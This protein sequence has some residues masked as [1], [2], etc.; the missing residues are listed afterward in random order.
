[1]R[2][3]I[4]K[5]LAHWH[6]SHP[7]RMFA[8]VILI[9]IFLAGLAGQMRI[10]MRWSDLLPSGDKRSEQFNKII[11]EF[12]TSTSLV[13]V[14]Q[15][16]EGRIKEFADQLAPRILEVT[17]TSKNESNQKKIDKINK[18]IEKLKAKPNKEPKIESRE[19]EIKELQARINKKLF[20]RV[21]YKA[22]ID[23]LKEHMLML[24]KEDDLKNLKDMFMDPN[25]TGLITNINNSLEKEYV[26][27]EE[28]I[29]TR[30]K[31]DGAFGFLDGIQNL[32][33]TLQKA[34]K[35]DNISEE[36]VLA[37]ADKLLF[38]EPYLLSYN[39]KALLLNAIPNFSLID[40]GLIIIAA[41]SVQA[42]INEMSKD[43]PDVEAGLTGFIATERDENVYASRSLGYS[44][45]IAVI[46]I[47]ILLMISFRMWVAPLFAVI[48]LIVG[49]IWAVGIT[50]I[51]VGHLN[52]MT[53]MMSIILL[54]LGIDFSIHLISGFAEWRSAGDSIGKA[55]KK[56]FLKSGKGIVTGAVTTAFAFMALIIS[57]S[58]GMKEMGLVIGT[59]LLAV[60]LTTMLFLPV[61]LVFRERRIERMR[62][63]KV[64]KF[65]RRDISFRFL[66]RASEWLSKRYV[67]TII[68]SIVISGLL[69]W[70]AFK[71]K[72]DHNY[73]NLEPKGLTSITLIDTVLEKF[74]LS[75]DYA[76]VIADNVDESREL[77]KRYRDLGSAARTDDI[78]LFLPSPEQQQKRIPHILEIRDKAQ[79]S[80]VRDRILQNEYT[81]LS[82]EI[83]RL[84]M[85]IMEMQDMAFIGGQDKVDDKCKEIV[86]DPEKP[87]SQNIIQDLLIILNSKEKVATEALSKFQQIFSPYFKKSTIE[88]ASTKPIQLDELPLNILDSYSNKTRDQF[89]LTVYPAANLWADAKVLN[90]FVDE[91]ERV[92]DKATGVAPIMR[93]LFQVIGR[94]G[95]NAALLTLVVVFLLLCLDFFN[96]RHALMA[97]VPLALGVF[98]MV[99][100]MNLTGMMLTIMNVMVLPIIIGIGIDDGVH[101]MHRWRNEGNSRIRTVF[102]STGKA[103]FLTSLTTMLA[104][105]SM[106]FSVFRGFASF[107][108]AMF[109]GV[110]ACFI[111]TVII[112]PG[113][114]GFIYKRNNK[115][116]ELKKS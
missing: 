95:R 84:E 3:K 85:N 29:S 40:Q 80:P 10:S 81:I 66:G 54:G 106:V 60:L 115:K 92:S 94:D 39:K 108:A 1:M 87:D 112:L 46:V 83:E 102:A 113:I 61:M 13:V 91:M 68:F 14:V 116:E 18:K 15:G 97:M 41:D 7:W 51:V 59:G 57:H 71:I 76:L 70:S 64:E 109:L 34:A 69:I 30:E 8:I 17:D 105:G 88:M 77:S 74:D 82:Q 23:F 12:V 16:E 32:V 28:S 73:W 104:F 111:T 52:L 47:L 6:A 36:E 38:G 101:I 89:L 62:E 53:V 96:P 33:L 25:L 63:K 44:T 79:S 37:A 9:T 56:T 114:F 72:F 31:E 75:I 110:G 90:R 21:D 48:N 103:I 19:D 35:D 42:I 55:M 5:K 98:W 45:L 50:Y 93:A 99:G 11:E 65:V 20:Q 26:G 22:P 27:Q 58:Q 67:F 24:V 86:G 43:F 2:E 78:S 4:L 107:G 49:L 100:L